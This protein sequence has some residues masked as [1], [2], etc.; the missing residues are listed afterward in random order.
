MG[1]YGMMLGA[2]LL[3]L[4]IDPN[5]PRAMKIFLFICF[6]LFSTNL[7]KLG[8]SNFVTHNLFQKDQKIIT[9]TNNISLLP[10]CS[11]IISLKWKAF[12][13]TRPC[14]ESNIISS[15]RC[16]CSFGMPSGHSS[17]TTLFFLMIFYEY[18]YGLKTDNLL[19]R[20]LRWV[21]SFLCFFII[22]NTLLSRLYIG[23]HSINQI[24]L[25]FL[26]GLSIFSVSKIC[27]ILNIFLKVIILF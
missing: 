23:A 19:R 5:K 3:I 10:C 24:I 4:F 17:K 18:L 1:I 9:I 12:R 11:I 27:P 22:F 6:D 26:W 16:S 15:I 25:G 2:V 14:F 8:K 7:L 20:V 13:D 21:A